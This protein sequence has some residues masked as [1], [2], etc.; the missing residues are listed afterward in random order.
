VQYR[1]DD[2]DLFE[3]TGL[4]VLPEWL[5]FNGHM[6]VAY[7]VLA[8][9]QMVDGGFDLIGIDAAYRAS[10]KYTMFALESHIT[11]QRELHLEDPLRI[12]VQF[13]GADGKRL[14][15]LYRM[16]H[17]TEGFLAATSEWMQICI[18]LEARRAATWDPEI[19]RKIDAVLARQAHLP[20]P[21]EVGRVM[22]V[23]P[24]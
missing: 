7:Y 6:N 16:Y 19:R 9:D 13:L 21:P 15:S 5:D 4:S 1:F 2:Q 22:Q 14:H 17:A 24:A 12:T 11:W 23:R 3:G 10:R 18:D 8:F 20:R